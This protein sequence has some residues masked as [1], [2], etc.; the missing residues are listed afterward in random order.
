[1]T[2]L[3]AAVTAEDVTCSHCRLPVSNALVEVGSVRQFCCQGCRV[4]YAVI[5][6]AGLERYYGFRDD[7]GAERAPAR[8]TGRTYAEYDDPAFRDLYCREAGEGLVAAD[9]Y[10]EGVHCS[11]CVWLIERAARGL[12][13]REATL[14]LGRSLVHLV[15]DRSLKLSELA[16]RFDSLGYPSHPPQ[17]ARALDA[18]RREDRVLLTRIAVA[19]AIAGNVMLMAFALYSGAFAG[20]DREFREFFRWGSLIITTPAVAWAALPFFRGGL[21]ALR[22]RTPH[23]DLPI[24]I[25]IS[26]GYV[27]GIVGT[28]RAGGEAYFDTITVLI[29]LLLV[30]RFIQRRQQHRARDAAE[31]LY[32]LAPAAARLLENG[33]V[34]EVPIQALSRGA[35][36]E[37]LAFGSIPVDGV[38]VE[39]HS[40][41]DASLLTGESR[42]I[43]VRPGD[44]V[45]AGCINVESRVV[46]RAENSG[47]AT[48]IAKLLA[49]VEEAR[50]RRAPIVVLAD[51]VA[52][53]FVVVAL[54]LAAF[55]LGLWLPFGA[56][57][58][59]D[60]AVA[61]LVV[62]CPCALGMATPLAVTVALGRAAKRGILVKGADALEALARPGLLV[63]D[64]T[65]TL[66][67]GRLKL[68]EWE[69]DAGVKA[70]VR[71]LEQHSTHPIA[72]AFL[73]ALRGEPELSAQAVCQQLGGGLEGTVS[74]R[75]VLV[76]SARHVEGVLGSLPVRFADAV[77]RHAGQGRTPVLIAVDREVVAL[78]AF[79]DPVRPDA[80]ESLREL[81]RLGHRLAIVSGDH[82]AVVRSVV[83][84]L[85]IDF[86]HASGAVSPEGKLAFVETARKSQPVFMVGDGVNDAGALSAATVGIAVHGGAE[87]S[88]A[89]ADAFLTRAGVAPVVDLVQG[90][91]RTLAVIRRNLEF[92]LCYNVVGVLLAMTGLI[93]PLL[94]AVLMPVSSLTVVASSFRAR[95]FGGEP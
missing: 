68:V 41:V 75:R 16:Q 13:C 6:D 66:T 56:T 58:A 64:K 93:G 84:E 31:L 44:R 24:S 83:R 80:R 17:G 22:T 87:A 85:G 25:G 23:M 46:V 32:S 59:V 71:A 62:T 76:G 95:T 38:V 21:A 81:A 91:R 20:M 48:R 11:A 65:G 50:R 57:M 19:G 79:G 52:G 12:G 51:V 92:S 18:R 69:G 89:A 61:L 37:V 39:G 54:A 60:H 35:L 67:E 34:R 30:G 73:D 14:D 70:L 82:P 29:F 90:A 8:V 7:S 78:A 27:W 10:V 3:P 28:F 86:E 77:E 72:A 53:R 88:L 1:M 5:H 47:A 26:A 4:A 9:L 43:D 15:Y 40:T 55:T 63:F 74:G 49:G 94:A 36:V 42:P 45:H 33:S 2:A